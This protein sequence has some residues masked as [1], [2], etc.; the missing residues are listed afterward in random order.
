MEPNP[1]NVWLI[2]CL[3]INIGSGSMALGKFGLH[4]HWHHPH[5]VVDFHHQRPGSSDPVATNLVVT[6]G[7]GADIPLEGSLKVV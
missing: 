4:T 7:I 5:L 3:D 6:L 1:A 2:S